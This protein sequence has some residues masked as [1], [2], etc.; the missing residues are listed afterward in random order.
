MS[1][2]LASGCGSVQLREARRRFGRFLPD[3]TFSTRDTSALLSFV[4]L[5]EDMSCTI[6][7]PSLFPRGWVVEGALFPAG[8]RLRVAV[9][10]RHPDAAEN[11]P[12]SPMNSSTGRPD[13]ADVFEHP[14]ALGVF[15][16]RPG[17]TPAPHRVCEEPT[18][19]AVLAKNS[20]LESELICDLP[21]KFCRH[22]R[23]PSPS[24]PPTCALRANV[25]P[26]TAE[27]AS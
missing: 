15:R 5:I 2:H 16:S 8:F 17:L 12:S 19:A 11:T 20:R 23:Q 9:L 22:M 18:A 26:G 4:W 7:R 3:G 1:F 6:R 13:H 24:R 21:R 27:T 14:S 25:A 10:A